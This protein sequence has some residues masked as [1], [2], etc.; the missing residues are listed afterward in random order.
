MLLEGADTIMWLMNETKLSMDV[1][2]QIYILY[3]GD[4]DKTLQT[5]KFLMPDP[6]VIQ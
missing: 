2:K 5:L 1:V 4:N 6:P 3:N